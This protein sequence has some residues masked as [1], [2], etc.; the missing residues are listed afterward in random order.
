MRLRCM[1]PVPLSRICW[2]RMEL[3]AP[4]EVADDLVCPACLK[5]VLAVETTGSETQVRCV[6]CGKHYECHDRIMRLLSE[7]HLLDHHHQE[8]EGNEYDTSDPEAVFHDTHKESWNRYYTEML[9]HDIRYVL[10]MMKDYSDE[11]T[12]VCLGAGAGFDLKAILSRRKFRR[13]LASDISLT[14]LSLVP[15]ALSSFEGSLGLFTSELGRCPI[16]KNPKCLGF[17]FQALH[18]APDI[19]AALESLLRRNFDNLIIVEPTTNWLVEILARLG[20]AKRKEYSGIMPDWINL[21]V[22]ERIAAKYGYDMK[23]Y[24]WWE[25]PHGLFMKTTPF[26]QC[27]LLSRLL[28][29]SAL[30]VSAITNAFRLGCMSVIL[31]RSRRPRIL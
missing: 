4:E 24:T 11:T 21:R 15:I 12:L 3:I 26:K 29:S 13:V 9:M 17:V 14:A 6:E 27:A 23:A 25:V 22:A 20:L 31:F 10:R 30:A 18:H 8:I 1:R 28:L 5:G 19:H 16:R 2:D 7:E